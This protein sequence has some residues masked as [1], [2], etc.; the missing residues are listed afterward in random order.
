MDA[1]ATQLSY[2][3]DAN[4]LQNVLKHFKRVDF[5]GKKPRSTRIHRDVRGLETFQKTA[6]CESAMYESAIVPMKSNPK[7]KK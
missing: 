1:D 7:A 3:K 5:Y 6:M 2:K 4:R